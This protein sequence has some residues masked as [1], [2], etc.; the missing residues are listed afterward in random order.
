MIRVIGVICEICGLKLERLA[1]HHLHANVFIGYGGVDPDD[2]AFGP[3]GIN[4]GSGICIGNRAA[5]WWGDIHDENTHRRV[6]YDNAVRE[7]IKA[8]MDGFFVEAEGV[9]S[10]ETNQME[11]VQQEGV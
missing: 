2:N 9:F 1:N 6:M 8:L 10:E 3:Q 4:Y 5:Q 7:G 11:P